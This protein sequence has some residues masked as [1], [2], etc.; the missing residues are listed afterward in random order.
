MVTIDPFRGRLIRNRT[1]LRTVRDARLIQVGSP[2]LGRVNS[3]DAVVDHVGAH[4]EELVTGGLT[5]SDSPL[6]YS[7][8]RLAR[9]K[10]QDEVCRGVRASDRAI[11]RQVVSR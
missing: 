9:T 3:H 7:L 2:S 1:V 6:G 4:G 8:G 5:L 10:N 11:E